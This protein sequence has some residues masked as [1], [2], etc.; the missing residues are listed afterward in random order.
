LVNF[1]RKPKKKK[2]RIQT[3]GGE[4]GDSK[5]KIKKA[6][7]RE[8]DV[9]APPFYSNLDS[10]EKLLLLLFLCVC[11]FGKDSCTWILFINTGSLD[12]GSVDPI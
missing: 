1:Q 6:R 12:G 9:I 10:L 3:F 2:K 7:P 5:G 8:A 4:T 11:P